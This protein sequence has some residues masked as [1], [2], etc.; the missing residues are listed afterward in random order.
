MRDWRCN[1]GMRYDPN[2]KNKTGYP[3]PLPPLNLMVF[4][5]RR[6]CSRTVNIGFL[7]GTRMLE[8][9]SEEVL[10]RERSGLCEHC[11]LHAST[12]PCSTWTPRKGS[13]QRGS[14]STDYLADL[15]SNCHGS[16]YCLINLRPPL[17]KLPQNLS[18]LT[19]TP[20]HILP[21]LYRM[22][23]WG[24]FDSSLDRCTGVGDNFK[25]Q[26]TFNALLC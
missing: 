10:R 18:G 24:H 2:F 5:V 16:Q 14:P 21:R 17:Y 13:N 25:F 6:T 4:C 1:L 8:L 23:G 19:P 3:P 26:C 11:P 22:S 7:S 12:S 15:V 20:L 9:R